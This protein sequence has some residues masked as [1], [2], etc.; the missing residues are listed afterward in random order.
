MM[1]SLMQLSVRACTRTK[2]N[3]G[4]SDHKTKTVK[5]VSIQLV[6]PFIALEDISLFQSVEQKRCY[7]HLH[8]K[9]F[10]TKWFWI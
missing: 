10:D 8:T 7:A 3:I 9:W 4:N 2:S 6:V 5:D 1:M